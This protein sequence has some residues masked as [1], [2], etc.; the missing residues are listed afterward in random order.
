[1]EYNFFPGLRS[2]DVVKIE[3]TG[4]PLLWERA[5]RTHVTTGRLSQVSAQH[6]VAFALR[7]GKAGLCEFDDEAVTET[8]RDEN[9][10]DVIFSDDTDRAFEMAH[11]HVQTRQGQNFEMEIA[12]AKGGPLNPM[13]DAELEKS[14]EPAAYRGS[15]RDVRAIADAVWSLDSAADVGE[16]MS[17]VDILK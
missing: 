9:R 7:R 2:E 16:M 10:P 4:H 17:P 1:M 13:T 12:A 8:L 3:L 5:D 14:T 15:K 6:A 11:M